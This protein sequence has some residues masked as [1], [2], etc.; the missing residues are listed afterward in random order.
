ML[1]TEDC[2]QYYVICHVC[3]EQKY[4]TVFENMLNDH[5]CL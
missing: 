2:N 4:N 5:V 3:Y 1:S